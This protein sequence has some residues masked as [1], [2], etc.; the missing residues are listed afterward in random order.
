MIE[1]FKIAANIRLV[2]IIPQH[3]FFTKKKVFRIELNL[4]FSFLDIHGKMLKII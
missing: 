3:Y 2:N 4:F 1:G